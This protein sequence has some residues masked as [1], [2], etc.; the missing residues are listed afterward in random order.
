MRNILKFII[1]FHFTILFVII[2]VFA[3]FLTIQTNHFQK[4]SFINSAN[5]ITGSLYNTLSSIT[6]YLNVKEENDKLAKENSELRLLLKS[7]YIENRINPIYVSDSSYK[8]KYDYFVAKVINNSVTKQLN[9][10]TINK[11][12]KQGVKPDMAV[13]CPQGVVGIVKEVSANFSVVIPTININAHVSAKIKKNGYFGTISWDGLDYKTVQLNEIPFHIKIA[14]GD[15]LITSGFSSV[16]PEGVLIGTIK[17]FD[18]SDGKDFYNIEVNLSTDFMSLNH[19]YVIHNLLKEE[20]ET[21]EKKSN[22]D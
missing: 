13:V 19:V 1:R 7:N 11:G 21:L 4:A 2:E 22:N 8:Q 9:L 20:Q 5:D 6:E 3:L 15:S 12:R 14:V 16:F 18:L 10:L 17:K